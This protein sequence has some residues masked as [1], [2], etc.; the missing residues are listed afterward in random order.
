MLTEL[1]I[2]C[3]L[4]YDGGMW[5]RLRYSSKN[6]SIGATLEIIGEKWSLLVLREAFFGLRRYED[7]RAAVGCARNILSARLA[8]LVENDILVRVAYR[9]PGAR[10]RYEYA[11]SPKGR[12]LL[13]ILVAL[14]QWGD[15]FGASKGKPPVLIRH[16]DCG[17]RVRAELRCAKHHGPLNAGEA[18]PE[19]G[20]G[21]E[22]VA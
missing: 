22:R 21:A 2:E 13:P 1:D 18:Y 9:E 6:C 11:L 12:E 7:I 20:P 8:T 10:K 16:R 3:Q 14:M 17:A 19:P 4:R 5:D 15:K